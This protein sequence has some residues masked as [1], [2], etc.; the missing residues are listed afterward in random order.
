MEK[1]YSLKGKQVYTQDLMWNIQ[2]AQTPEARELATYIHWFQ[3]SD[4]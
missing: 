3:L 4:F 1:T 2:W